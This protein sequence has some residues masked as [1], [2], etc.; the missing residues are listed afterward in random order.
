M[1]SHH[2]TAL[3]RTPLYSPLQS[4]NFCLVPCPLLGFLCPQVLACQCP[5]SPVARLCHFQHS[6]L[7]LPKPNPGCLSANHMAWQTRRAQCWSKSWK[8]IQLNAHPP[9]LAG[10]EANF[11]ALSYLSSAWGTWVLASPWCQPLPALDPAVF[12][13]HRDS[14]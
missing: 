1:G 2:A 7:H 4:M 13:L 9:F 11:V 8:Q 5:A 12:L 3:F 10:E 6:S 14:S